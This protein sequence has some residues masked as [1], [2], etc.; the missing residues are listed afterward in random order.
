[1]PPLNLANGALCLST[2]KH[3]GKSGTGRK[4]DGIVTATECACSWSSVIQTTQNSQSI[5]NG[6]HQIYVSYK[7]LLDRMLL[8]TRKLLNQ[9]LVLIKLKSTL[10]NLMITIMN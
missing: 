8:L 6:D 5:H 4:M 9:G 1:M 7:D 10:R 2:P 3:N